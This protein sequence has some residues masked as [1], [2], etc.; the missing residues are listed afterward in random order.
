VAFDRAGIVMRLPSLAELKSG[1]HVEIE[2][3]P[4]QLGLE[5]RPMTPPS[6][7]VDVGALAASLAQVN[8]AAS[9]VAG[10]LS[11]MVPKLTAAYFPDGVGGQAQLADG[12]LSPLA[13][14]PAPVVGPV[15]YFEPSTVPGARAVVFARAPSRILLG[16]HPKKT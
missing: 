2:G 4:F 14:V 9:K 16:G 10:A 5:L 6:T 15:P 12:R 1:A 7:R 13:V 11:F 3:A 8:A